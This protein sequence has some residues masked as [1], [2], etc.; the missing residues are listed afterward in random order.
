MRTNEPYYRVL[1]QLTNKVYNKSLDLFECVEDMELLNIELVEKG[2]RLHD[3]VIS[4]IKL[5]NVVVDFNLVTF[6]DSILK[7]DFKQIFRY[8]KE[9]KENGENHLS[10]FNIQIDKIQRIL[11]SMSTYVD[12]MKNQLPEVIEF[13]EKLSLTDKEALQISLEYFNNKKQNG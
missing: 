3:N 2:I 7:E 4:E 9:D 10:L 5:L 12:F 6:V 1:D 13:M 11:I 8:S